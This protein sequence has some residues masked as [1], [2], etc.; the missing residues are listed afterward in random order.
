VQ[1]VLSDA[2]E[3][4]QFRTRINGLAGPIHQGLTPAELMVNEVPDVLK[5]RNIDGRPAINP[6]NRQA[7]SL[8]DAT[9]GAACESV[10]YTT[11]D[12]AGY[13]ILTLAADLRGQAVAL[14]GSAQVETTL[15]RLAEAFPMPVFNVMERFTI[16]EI[17]GV[18]RALLAEN[19]SIRDLRSILEALLETAEPVDVDYGKHIVLFARDVHPILNRREPGHATVQ[20]LAE[21]VRVALR[22]QISHQ[23]ARG[24]WTLTVHL[25]SAALEARVSRAVREPLDDDERRALFG[26][27]RAATAK[28]AGAEAVILTTVPVRGALQALIALEFP[29]LAV[30]SYN[31]LRPDLNIQP[32]GRIDWPPPAPAARRVK[33]EPRA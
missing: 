26:A 20:E 33:P 3:P 28:G 23:Q 16:S 17:G 13:V 27:I 21:N 15:R 6:A 4:T 5:R 8:I 1:F 24:G 25:L 18:L 29:G 19:V 11:W 14:F 10:G 9:D 30:L 12:T 31:E 2:L 7:V 32:L 22:R